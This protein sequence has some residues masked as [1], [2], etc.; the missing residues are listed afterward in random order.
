MR[1]WMRRRVDVLFSFLRV[2]NQE[3]KNEPK[4]Y[5]GNRI[6]LIVSVWLRAAMLTQQKKTKHG[7]KM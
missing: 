4:T 5:Q 2:V 6:V 7:Y 1:N 3:E